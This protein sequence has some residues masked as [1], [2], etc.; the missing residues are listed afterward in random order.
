MLRSHCARWAT[1][2]V[3]NFLKMRG[4]RLVLFGKRSSVRRKGRNRYLATPEWRKAKRPLR[5]WRRRKER[6]NARRL[7]RNHRRFH[8]LSRGSRTRTLGLRETRALRLRRTSKASSSF[9]QGAL[10]RSLR[11]RKSF[12]ARRPRRR[13]LR[14]RI[15]R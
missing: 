3:R 12:R 5:V 8:F 7:R 2:L 10:R 11:P 9:F 6:R 4:T 1:L 15:R 13:I 14:R